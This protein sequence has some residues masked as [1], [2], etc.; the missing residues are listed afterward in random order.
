MAALGTTLLVRVL[1][2]FRAGVQKAVPQDETR[3]TL[4][5]KLSKEDGW[6]DWTLPAETLRNRWR[7]FSPWPGATTVLPGGALLK[8]HEMRVEA[9]VENAVPGTILEATGLG[10]LVA[11]GH[12][13]LRLT[14]V[15]PAGK[16]SMPGSAFLCGYR[17]PIGERLGVEPQE[18]V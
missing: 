5:R 7:G 16:K 14:Q 4:A 11:T 3:V 9:G 17:L 15:Q 10:P 18:R 8:I 2:E 12:G 1:D 6:M 13:A